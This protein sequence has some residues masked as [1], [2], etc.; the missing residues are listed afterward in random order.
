MTTIEQRL[1]GK[2]IWPSVADDN[3]VSNMSNPA[4]Q[5]KMTQGATAPPRQP[6]QRLGP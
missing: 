2:R 3:N 4:K 1:D 5:P 6:K